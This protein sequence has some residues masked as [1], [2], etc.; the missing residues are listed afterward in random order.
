LRESKERRILAEELVPGDVIQLSE[1]DRISAD[2]R[3][4]EVAELRIDQSTLTGESH[5]VRKIS[6]AILKTDLAYA[7]MPNLV[8]A[9]TN[10][11]AGTGKAVVIATGMRTEFGKIAQMTQAV[12]EEL[13]P[14][15]KEMAFATRI[16]TII[17]TVI[18][19]IFFLL[20]AILVGVNLAESF[21][22]AMGMVVAFVPE[23][24]LPLVTLS[25]AMGT[26]RMARR[27]TLIKKLSAVETLGCTTV[28]CTDKTG[29]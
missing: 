23:G 11:A 16:V 8:F 20:A 12:E 13:S 19:I 27:H 10:V 2:G 17:A 26:Q 7:E 24:M 18:G 9:G 4:V 21:I 1:G 6:E 25:L 5:A 22:F 29:S 15:Q 14:L 3:L 28:I